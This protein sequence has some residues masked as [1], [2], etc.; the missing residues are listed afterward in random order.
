MGFRY[1]KK[2]YSMM[3]VKLFLSVLFLS[4]IYIFPQQTQQ[5]TPN[6]AHHVIKNPLKKSVFQAHDIEHMSVES[7]IY[8]QRIIASHNAHM[9]YAIME[10]VKKD[11]QNSYAKEL[12]YLLSQLDTTT[13]VR[14]SILLLTRVVSAYQ[15]MRHDIANYQESSA[16]QE[17]AYVMMLLQCSVVLVSIARRQ[18]L[19]ILDEIHT[20]LSYWREQKRSPMSYFLHKSPLKWVAGKRQAD[21]IATNIKKL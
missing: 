6:L 1:M 8:L 11:T 3:S 15:S 14:Q 17:R 10:W 9:K 2:I 5:K 19:S 13:T 7:D 20:S 16:W 21:E 12:L 4:S 18:L